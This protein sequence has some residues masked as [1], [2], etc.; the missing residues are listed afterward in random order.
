M[1]SLTSPVTSSKV[2]DTLTAT[3]TGGEA[4]YTYQWYA[5]GEAI[6]GADDDELLVTEDMLGAELSV[7]VTD[8]NGDKKYSDETAEVANPDIL[9]ENVAQTKANAIRITF[10]QDASDYVTKEEIEV[11][12]E[13]GT[14]V[15]PVNTLEWSLDGTTA[16]ATLSIALTDG[17][18]Y[19]VA[20]GES[21]ETF[22]ASIGE[23][24]KV[25]IDTDSAEVNTK[26][27]IKFTLYNDD[28]V[29]ITSSVNIDATCSV[30]VDGNVTYDVARASK[31]TITMDTV[32]GTAD[33]TVTYNSNKADA[34]DI[35]ATKTVTCISAEAVVGAKMYA[36]SDDPNDLSGCAK[37]YLSSVGSS[38]ETI[39]IVEDG[40]TDDLFFCALDGN[41]N[42]ISYDTYEVESSN[43]D[44]ASAS[45]TVDNGK[46]AQ[47]TLTGNTV[48]KANVV[49][50]ASKN[51]A[52]T[53]YTIPV[54]VVKEGVLD[55]ITVTASLPTI[56]NAIDD[57]YYGTL[58]V[59]AYDSND[60]D[61]T[62]D[63]VVAYETVNK[64]KKENLIVE[65][66]IGEFTGT[67]PTGFYT[68]EA[69]GYYYARG[70][71]KGSQN[72][73]VSVS[74]NDIVKEKTVGITVRELPEKAWNI[75]DN[76]GETGA[77]IT[78]AIE[79]DKTTIDEKNMNTTKGVANARLKAMIG[80]DFA[81]YVRQ[82]TSGI[83]PVVT[84]GTGFTGTE[85]VSG[86]KA[87]VS[88][89][90]GF[91]FV[92]DAAGVEANGYK[93]T[94]QPEVTGAGT[95]WTAS[96]AT[97]KAAEAQT[98]T[99]DNWKLAIKAAAATAAV[100]VNFTDKLI[101]VT[102]KTAELTKTNINALFSGFDGTETGIYTITGDNV[103][104]T[105]AAIRTIT[106][107]EDELTVTPTAGTG[108]AAT[109]YVA[110]V[111]AGVT[112]AA[113]GEFNP[114]KD[115]SS[116]NFVGTVTYVYPAT[117]TTLA[118]AKTDYETEAA[119]DDHAKLFTIDATKG[120]L[121]ATKIVGTSITT[122]GTDDLTVGKSTVK[123]NRDSFIFGLGAG[124]KYG[125]KFSTTGEVYDSAVNVQ[126]SKDDVRESLLGTEEFTIDPVSDDDYAFYV[127]GD[128]DKD[129][130]FAK[131]G[132]Y[133]VIF[134]YS[135]A[136]G[137]DKESVTGLTVKNTLYVPTITVDKSPVDSTNMSDIIEH[138]SASVDMNNNDSS[139]ESIDPTALWKSVSTYGVGTVAEGTSTKLTA[140]YAGVLEEGVYFFV[141]INTT[142]KTE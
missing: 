74:Q 56:T 17:H 30:S 116:T 128:S 79:L 95:T 105:T 69:T 89:T 19:S 100:N 117:V 138:L 10:N 124:V 84:I 25:V 76:L 35:T 32:G 44:V 121:A 86:T 67:E 82:D 47:I 65:S 127:S 7:S 101:T 110:P 96:G 118:E 26:T 43:D 20:Y 88:N 78:Y 37:F 122:G 114:L 9:I 62:D 136:A 21:E 34:E 48:G 15:I 111:T 41:D 52:D 139:H 81:G 137:N 60:T 27:D 131:P 8:A 70:A 1:Y 45:A 134:T 58:T 59:K 112:Y 4:P 12:D 46:F 39:E 99:L 75:T 53:T 11:A 123:V 107:A 135:D 80:S 49:V 92:A 97:F 125:T 28:D 38:T 40:E 108:V 102:P 87:S 83:L 3:V 2:G 115:V 109:A 13:D 18:T 68:D 77:K 119:G 51:G 141:P 6:E 50:K 133:S 103:A 29:D 93:F 54:E 140:K 33:V 72:I 5:D 31:A 14:L 36:V 106:M 90:G 64:D 24:A 22:V 113:N 71:Q 16:D 23:V 130:F 142:F 55:H 42:A 63:C 120:T 129:G 85:V 57:D 132:S 73:R 98:T 61:I 104:A 91:T 94:T 66:L 126:N